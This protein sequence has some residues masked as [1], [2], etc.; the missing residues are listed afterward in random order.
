MVEDEAGS[1]TTMGVDQSATLNDCCTVRQATDNVGDEEVPTRPENNLLQNGGRPRKTRAGTIWK[2]ASSSK[3]LA[4]LPTGKQFST[5]QQRAK[6]DATKSLREVQQQQPAAARRSMVAPLSQSSEPIQRLGNGEFKRSNDQSYPEDCIIRENKK[7]DEQKPELR[8]RSRS[9]NTRSSKTPTTTTVWSG[10][11][12]HQ[13]EQVKCISPVDFNLTSTNNKPKATASSTSAR[14]E[15]MG[16]GKLGSA[17][18]LGSANKV[19]ETTLSIAPSSEESNLIFVSSLLHD[20]KPTASEKTMK[21][22]KMNAS[23]SLADSAKQNDFSR[24]VLRSAATSLAGDSN[25]NQ[26]S[27]HGLLMR[28]SE[29]TL[30]STNSKATAS[31]LPEVIKSSKRTKQIKDE[32]PKLHQAHSSGKRRSHVQSSRQTARGGSHGSV[33]DKNES[34]IR[35]NKEKSKASFSPATGEHSVSIPSHLT[36]QSLTK[37]QMNVPSAVASTRR[38]SVPSSHS[39]FLV[40]GDYFV[41]NHGDVRHQVDD[42]SLVK[43]KEGAPT[44]PTSTTA[45]VSSHSLHSCTN[46]PN[47]ESVQKR[48]ITFSQPLGKEKERG[49]IQ[50][51]RSLT[52]ATDVA[53]GSLGDDVRRNNQQSNENG[54][55]PLSPPTSEH[56]TSVSAHFSKKPPKR[57]NVAKWPPSPG[58]ETL[59]A[60]IQSTRSATQIGKLSVYC[61]EDQDSSTHGLNSKGGESGSSLSSQLPEQSPQKGK[62]KKAK[63]MTSEQFWGILRATLA[64]PPASP[65]PTS[66]QEK[67]ERGNMSSSRSLGGTKKREANTYAQLYRHSVH[68][69][70]QSKPRRS[71]DQSVSSNTEQQ[72]TEITRQSINGSKLNSDVELNTNNSISKDAEQGFSPTNSTPSI[73][74]RPTF[75]LAADSK[76][77]SSW[78][79]GNPKNIN[80]VFVDALDGEDHS[81]ILN[82]T[83]E[84]VFPSSEDSHSIGRAL[85]KGKI[86]ITKASCSS[87][88]LG[89]KNSTGRLAHKKRSNLGNVEQGKRNEQKH[90]QRLSSRKPSKRSDNGECRRASRSSSRQINLE[91]PIGAIQVQQSKEPGVTAESNILPAP[92]AQAIDETDILPELGMART[93]VAQLV[94]RYERATSIDSQVFRSEVADSRPRIKQRNDVR[95][96]QHH[97]SS[98]VHAVEK[99]K[100]ERIS[101]NDDLLS[102]DKSGLDNTGINDIE[103]V[104]VHLRE[105]ET[106]TQAVAEPIDGDSFDVNLP[107]GADRLQ[108]VFGDVDG[109]SAVN[110]IEDV[111]NGLNDVVCGNCEYYSGAD[112]PL[113]SDTNLME[114]DEMS[115]LDDVASF[116]V[117]NEEDASFGN[118]SGATGTGIGT[119]SCNSD[120]QAPCRDENPNRGTEAQNVTF[121]LTKV[122]PGAAGSTDESLTGYVGDAGALNPVGDAHN[123]LQSSHARSGNGDPYP[124]ADAHDITVSKSVEEKVTT[125]SSRILPDAGFTDESPI[126]HVDENG[127]RVPGGDADVSSERQSVAV[128][129][130]TAKVVKSCQDGESTDKSFSR[131]VDDTHTVNSLHNDANGITSNSVHTGNGNYNPGADADVSS[132]IQSVKKVTANPDVESTDESLTGYVD[133]T[134]T[135]NPVGDDENGLPSNDVYSENGFHYPGADADEDPVHSLHEAA[136]SFADVNGEDNSL[137]GGSAPTDTGNLSGGDFSHCDSPDRGEKTQKETTKTSKIFPDAEST[138]ESLLHIFERSM[139]ESECETK[140]DDSSNGERTA[141]VAG[142]YD[143]VVCGLTGAL[144]SHYEEQLIRGSIIESSYVRDGQDL[145]SVESSPSIVSGLDDADAYVQV[146]THADASSQPANDHESAVDL[147]GTVVTT[148]RLR[149]Y[150]N[151]YNGR[152]HESST[153]AP[154]N[155][156]NDQDDHIIQAYAASV[157]GHEVRITDRAS[158]EGEEG[159]SLGSESTDNEGTAGRGGDASCL[160]V[161]PS[162]QKDG[163][164]VEV[165]IPSSPGS[166]WP[167]EADCQSVDASTGGIMLQEEAKSSQSENSNN[168][169]SGGKRSGTFVTPS[170]ES[171]DS[172]P[173]SEDARLKDASE[174]TADNFG[175]SDEDGYASADALQNCE[176]DVERETTLESTGEI[177]WKRVYSGSNGVSHIRGQH[178][179]LRSR[180][181]DNEGTPEAVPRPCKGTLQ[182]RITNKSEVNYA[183]KEYAPIE[184]QDFRDTCTHVDND[185]SNGC[186]S[187]LHLSY[188]SGQSIGAEAES[189]HEQAQPGQFD[190]DDVL[191]RR[192]DLVVVVDDDEPGR[193]ES[194]ANGLWYDVD[195]DHHDNDTNTTNNNNDPG[196]KDVS[197]NELPHDGGDDDASGRKDA[198]TKELPHDGGGDDAS[199]RRYSI[200]NEF[201]YDDD[202]DASERKDFSIDDE[203]P[204]DDD[205]DDHHHAGKKSAITREL[206]FDVADDDASGR[207]D[208]ISNELPYDDVASG[209]KDSVAN[210]LPYDDFPDAPGE[211]ELIA[212]ES[213]D[214]DDDDDDASGRKDFSAN[215]LPYSNDGQRGRTDLVVNGLRYDVDDDH[216]DKNNN[217]TTDTNKHNEPGRKDAI[218]KELPHDGDDDDA[219][220]RRDSI[221]NEFPYDDDDA[222]ERKDF[223]IGDEVPGDDDDDDHHHA[224]KKSAITRELTYD[225]ADDDASGRKDT[226]SNE[227]PYDDG[228]SG[229]KDSVTNQL[230]YDDFHDA[231]GEREL[232]ANESADNDDDDDDASGRKDFSAN[233]LPYSKNDKRRR[234]DSVACALPYDDDNNNEPGGNGAIPNELPYDDDDGA[235]ARKDSITNQLW[236]N[237]DDDASGRKNVIAIELPYSI[238]DDASGRDGLIANELMVNDEE[239]RGRQDLVANALPRDIDDHA[240]GRQ[241]VI[242]NELPYDEDSDVLGRQD[243]ITN[244]IPCNYNDVSGGK[245][246]STYQ[247]QSEDDDVSVRRHLIPKAMSYDE[248]VVKSETEGNQ[249][250]AETE[251]KTDSEDGSQSSGVGRID[252]SFLSDD[253]FFTTEGCEDLDAE[254]SLGGDNTRLND[255]TGESRIAH[256]SLYSMFPETLRCDASANSLEDYVDPQGAFSN[257]TEGE[258]TVT[259]SN[260]SGFVNPVLVAKPGFRSSD[261]CDHTRN[262]EPIRNP[263]L[264]REGMDTSY[265]SK[266]LSCL[267]S[268][269]ASPKNL[270]LLTVQES[271]ESVVVQRMDNCTDL[272]DDDVTAVS[273]NEMP[274]ELQVTE[275]QDDIAQNQTPVL[276]PSVKAPDGKPSVSL[277]FFV[278]SFVGAFARNGKHDP[279]VAAKE[280]AESDAVVSSAKE[281]YGIEENDGAK[282][283]DSVVPP[284]KT[285]NDDDTGETPLLLVK[286]LSHEEA[287][288]MMIAKMKKRMEA[289]EEERHMHL[290]KIQELKEKL[291]AKESKFKATTGQFSSKHLKNASNWQNMDPNQD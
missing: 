51:S 123:G 180:P 283:D 210:Q 124:G 118:D 13:E 259:Y 129:R 208:T 10:G 36:H 212:N 146:A 87:R 155:E 195:D 230:P 202:D 122:L 93:S 257:G 33:V 21:K 203:V 62:L 260:I 109:T 171:E 234:T 32:Q 290:L 94:M 273:R 183:P 168:A 222:S 189:G 231:P 132:G 140:T 112:A 135:V 207:K 175:S 225:V 265:R 17:R 263:F 274:V 6:V 184:S 242:T 187:C 253:S 177:T 75:Q 111:D 130:V 43:E 256:S 163:G 98:T 116:A 266:I 198:I 16:R 154:L 54:G 26:T 281:K 24:S 20:D 197:T 35:K 211:K 193:K 182:N 66:R 137:D 133:D 55:G 261:S 185:D 162:D 149:I 79:K 258:S 271:G 85:A 216:N 173:S 267:S 11:A 236:Y 166:Y 89:S 60:R 82:N 138:D 243:V 169:D 5:K 151:D 172:V 9:R 92:L 241:F 165:R 275:A 4:G 114:V 262:T 152:K 14:K 176:T 80:N 45:S 141:A 27:M 278:S 181:F 125:K 214:N 238:D 269:S 86:K 148:K 110:R 15:K 64:A 91:E 38:P 7:T 287:L 46:S 107:H 159:E 286:E 217:N 158:Y 289:M 270:N 291:D 48:T 282:I 276:A 42:K 117:D 100:A 8:K 250:N 192:K 96:S 142:Y 61:L 157:A 47:R 134:S 147:V 83:L 121:K 103:V 277:G 65:S 213:A 179:C 81:E 73:S 279:L 19:N 229:R 40:R 221:T 28:K 78:L 145:N 74:R 206:T 226:I 161:A 23:Q 77:S 235:S 284:S 144:A 39:A 67:M 105:S 280:T 240:L 84:E 106:E 3:K 264:N 178:S 215:G 71:V 41:S 102:C 233:G 255:S 44:S 239:V 18:S 224:D 160:N 37:E 128:E 228:A 143:T 56:T 251:F 99:L 246:V 285:G 170:F 200:T 153:I 58:A 268:T 232:I 68:V 25:G 139:D 120:H 108:L 34:P 156:G 252:F 90:S 52:D 196:R 205:D 227:L 245:N 2:A 237:N 1:S 69:M 191:S 254:T 131:Y 115:S 164:A 49:R 59:R 101:Q 188:E 248:H 244:E 53:I 29:E 31:T 72:K 219:S 119:S 95:G 186:D 220:G 63:K 70:M 174:Q 126:C 249:D 113:K 194:V 50:S 127:D 104:Q 12:L 190:D 199:G 30:S 223:R 22:G 204:G 272:K 97:D 150:A 88:S 247:L 57:E 288:Q 201:P 76:S 167:A 136:S 209:R 218:T